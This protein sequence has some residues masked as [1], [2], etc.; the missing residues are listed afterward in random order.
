LAS[1]FLITAFSIKT[2]EAQVQ[3]TSNIKNDDPNISMATAYM[4]YD[5]KSDKP[6]YVGIL[7]NNISQELYLLTMPSEEGTKFSTDFLK[8]ASFPK[9][10]T[11]ARRIYYENINIIVREKGNFVGQRRYENI[12]WEDISKYS[13]EDDE[14]M[15][16][17]NGTTIQNTQNQWVVIDSGAPFLRRLFPSFAL[18]GC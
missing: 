11:S 18:Y 5:G 8:G 13:K 2:P 4:M 15:I 6:N 10:V 7:N 14:V 1:C 9:N 12:N 17:F 3:K 16:E